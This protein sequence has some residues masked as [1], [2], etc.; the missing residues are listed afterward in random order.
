MILFLFIF[1]PVIL[2]F[3]FSFLTRKY[4]NPYRLTFVFGKKGSGKST[5][6]T[7]IAV[8]NLKAKKLVFS[9]DK[10][11][12]GTI[13]FNPVEIGKKNFPP[14]SVVLIDEVSLIW[15]NRDWKKTPPELIQWF[16]F[17]RKYHVKVYLFSVKESH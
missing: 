6:M 14:E 15:S 17:Q 13:Y 5:L 10:T 2:V 9:N 11:M 8:K 7:K 12:S 1:F 4:V 3:S 16:R